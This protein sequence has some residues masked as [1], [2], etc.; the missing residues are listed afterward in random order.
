[1]TTETATERNRRR[2]QEAAER[3]LS[4][5]SRLSDGKLTIKSL[6]TEAGL[7]RPYLYRGGYKDLAADFEAQARAL[8]ARGDVPDERLAE[9]RRLRDDL[10][11]SQTRAQRHW[12]EAQQLREDLRAAASQIAYLSAQND[13]LRAQLR[14]AAVVVSVRADEERS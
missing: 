1:M 11:K 12:N 5:Q 2:V 3:L 9:L 7:P 4:G 6:A 10:A 14:T 13:G 8:L